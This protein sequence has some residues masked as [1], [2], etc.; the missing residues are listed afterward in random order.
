MLA[1]KVNYISPAIKR[2]KMQLSPIKVFD[3]RNS[4]EVQSDSDSYLGGKISVSIE[5]L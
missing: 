4:V 2:K 3:S 5:N 1:Q